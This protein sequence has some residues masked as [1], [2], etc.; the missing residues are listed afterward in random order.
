[1]NCSTCG[2]NLVSCR[3]KS[4]TDPMRINNS[5]GVPELYR[6]IRPPQVTQ[7]TLV[8][9]LWLL[10]VFDCVNSLVLSRPRIHLRCVSLMVKLDANVEA[11]TFLQSEQWQTNVFTNPSSVSGCYREL[12]IEISRNGLWKGHTNDIWTVPQ[13]QV[14]VASLSLDQPSVATLAK[15]K[16][17]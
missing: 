16:A 6:H 17:D 14:A 3:E 8:M 2:L 4:S 10:I 9:S 13:R 7:K 1:M 15:G 11:V 5:P 12:D